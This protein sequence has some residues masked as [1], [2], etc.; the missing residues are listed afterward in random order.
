MSILFSRKDPPRLAADIEVVL[1][2]GLAFMHSFMQPTNMD[3]QREREV[4][5]I[6]EEH[7]CSWVGMVSFHGG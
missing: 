1:V 6:N 2:A 7:A 3:E 4:F 5:M